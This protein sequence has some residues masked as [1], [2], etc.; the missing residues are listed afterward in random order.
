MIASALLYGAG[1][2]AARL[3]RLERYPPEVPVSLAQPLVDTLR[4]RGSLLSIVDVG[5]GGTLAAVLAEASHLSD[6]VRGALV[7]A[8]TAHACAV[9]DVVGSTEPSTDLAAHL[10][11]AA[12]SRW[13]TA[14]ARALVGT[15]GDRP[16]AI[17]TFHIGMAGTGGCASRTVV[18]DRGAEGNWGQAVLLA[19]RF[20]EEQLR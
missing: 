5:A 7:T 19:L 14:A 6:A 20:A 17:E 8:T 13:R 16:T 9:F 18:A 2:V 3:L 12:R 4:R 10:A 1:V 11:A 15:A